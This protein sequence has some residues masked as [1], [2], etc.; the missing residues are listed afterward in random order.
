[1]NKQSGLSLVGLIVI[2]VL[3]AL[4]ALVGMKVFPEVVEYFAITK[5][6]KATAMD[7]ASRS[8][9]VADLRRS[10]DKRGEI[11]DIKSITGTD[12]D[13]SKDGGEIVISFAYSK[14]IPLYGPVSLL[15][16][17]EGSTAK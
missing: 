11:D 10:F 4:V 14:K 17:F 9:S 6:A 5:V 8:A 1:M 15:I 16:D 13:I 12:L 2:C 3:I 7:P